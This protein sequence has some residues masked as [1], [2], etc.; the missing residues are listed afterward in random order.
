MIN[1]NIESKELTKMFNEWVFNSFVGSD[2]AKKEFVKGLLI[3]DVV[4]TV[5]NVKFE[6]YKND[7]NTL[8]PKVVLTLD[9]CRTFQPGT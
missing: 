8:I 6:L 3:S 2:E 1:Y 5:E 7:D 4:F 9:V